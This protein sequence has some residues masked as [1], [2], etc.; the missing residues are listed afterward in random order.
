[1]LQHMPAFFFY[2]P[3]ARPATRVFPTPPLVFFC[4]RARRPGR[5][6][7]DAGRPLDGASLG[8]RVFSGRLARSSAG[9][10]LFSPAA[11][12]RGRGGAKKCPLCTLCSPAPSPRPKTDEKPPAT[13]TSPSIRSFKKTICPWKHNCSSRP[14]R[15]TPLA[16]RRRRGSYTHPAPPVR[17]RARRLATH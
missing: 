11:G 12:G 8:P 10:E 13:A 2:R 17:S 6:A 1:V 4:G 5:K 9:P 7:L 15:K 14:P 3:A 16:R